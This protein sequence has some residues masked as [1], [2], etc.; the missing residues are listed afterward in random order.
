MNDYF[1]TYLE[2]SSSTGQAAAAAG[3]LAQPPAVAAAHPPS[4]KEA[5]DAPCIA[6][7]ALQTGELGAFPVDLRYRAFFPEWLI[8]FKKYW[9]GKDWLGCG[10]IN[11]CTL[12]NID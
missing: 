12:P 3:A 2:N 1:D 4:R 7:G 9:C 5:R 11:V 10:G 8:G 6:P